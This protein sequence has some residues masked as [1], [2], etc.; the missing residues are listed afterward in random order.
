MKIE[1]STQL[2]TAQLIKE[3]RGPSV[4]KSASAPDEVQLSNLASQLLAADNEP[5]FD[6]GRVA[7]IKQ[8]I[9]E[10]KFSINADAIADRLIVSARE[11]VDSRK[12]S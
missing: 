1:Q 4:K 7:E 12:Q 9:S 8:A 2:N 10:G 11:L 6:A 3:M 5:P